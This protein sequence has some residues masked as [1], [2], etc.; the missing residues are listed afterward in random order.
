MKFWDIVFKLTTYIYIYIWDIYGTMKV[1]KADASFFIFF[2]LSD[3]L[4]G[5][6]MSRSP[7][8]FSLVWLKHFFCSSDNWREA[9][10]SHACLYAPTGHLSGR[11]FSGG[12]ARCLMP[13]SEQHKDV[14]AGTLFR[15]ASGK[16]WRLA[17]RT[18]SPLAWEFTLLF[19]NA[20]C[21][22]CSHVQSCSRVS[23]YC[24]WGCW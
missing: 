22:S 23:R 14:S 11:Q 1:S 19:S 20:N 5:N 12:C 7:R 17:E 24:F 21:S 4:I 16:D 3:N 18:K 10:E 13:C 6:A 9:Y 2:N 15:V 8:F